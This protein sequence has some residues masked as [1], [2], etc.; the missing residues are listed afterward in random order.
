MDSVIQVG[1]L[2]DDYL[3]SISEKICPGSLENLPP[4]LTLLNGEGEVLRLMFD[5]TGEAE[6]LD[7]AVDAA[8]EVLMAISPSHPQRAIYLN[9]LGSRLRSRFDRCETLDAL[10]EATNLF[11]E[12]VNSSQDHSYKFM[13]LNNLSLCLSDWFDIT[14]EVCYLERAIRSARDALETVSTDCAHRAPCLDL[15]S[16]H[17]FSRFETT[18]TLEDLEE[19]IQLSRSALDTLTDGRSD[20]GMYLNNLAEKLLRRSERLQSRE[21][22]EEAVRIGREAVKAAPLDRDAY[23]QYLKNLSNSLEAL[24]TE[25]QSLLYLNEAIELGQDAVD[26][27]ADDDPTRALCL[28]SLGSHFL[29]R[30]AATWQPEDLDESIQLLET[31]FAMVSITHPQRVG[32]MSNLGDALASRFEL[33]GATEDLERAIQLARD[34]VNATARGHPDWLI[35]SMSLSQSLDIRYGVTLAIK[36][37]EEGISRD[38]EW[39]AQFE[40][41]TDLDAAVLAAQD[42]VDITSAG[43]SE[44]WRSL[45]KLANALAIRARRTNSVHDRERAILSKQEA[46]DLVC[47]GGGHY[48]QLGELDDIGSLL[49]DWPTMA[50]N[51]KELEKSIRIG[52]EVLES[53]PHAHTARS[54]FLDSLSARLHK[55]FQRFGNRVDLEDATELARA[56]VDATPAESHKKVERLNRLSCRLEDLFTLTAETN[57]LDESISLAQKVVGLTPSDHPFRAGYMN[58]LATCYWQRFQR[59]HVTA[60]IQEA[61]KYSTCALN[62]TSQ[63]HPDRAALLQNLSSN[64]GE[65]FLKTGAEEDLQDAIQL[66]QMAL[67]MI[68]PG[69]PNRPICLDYLGERL[70]DRFKRTQRIEDLEKSI[71]LG[72]EA[73]FSVP[74]DYPDRAMYLTNLGVRLRCSLGE[75]KSAVADLEDPSNLFTEALALPTA[76]PLDRIKAGQAAFHHLVSKGDWKSTRSVAKFV[77]ELLPNLMLRWITRDDQQHLLRHLARFSSLACAAVLQEGGT[78]AVALEILERG[79]GIIA[80]FAIDSQSDLSELK[81]KAPDLYSR[82]VSVR[83]SI[84]ARLADNSRLSTHA[85]DEQTDEVMSPSGPTISNAIARRRDDIKSLELLESQIREIQGFERF[86]LPLTPEELITFGQDGPVVS[87]NVT[88]HRSDAFLI[89][90]TEIIGLSLPKLRYSD[91]KQNVRKLV[92]KQNISR[93][94]PSTKPERNKELLRILEW[95]WDVAVKV[96]LQRLDLL[97]EVDDHGPLPRVWWVTSGYMGL[98]P[99][100]AAGDRFQSTSDFVVSSYTPILKALKYSRERRQ[101]LSSLASLKTLIVVAPETLGEPDLKTERE[102]AS[103]TTGIGHSN[104]TVLERPAKLD[105]LEDM[106]NHHIVHF[107]C[108]GYSSSSDPSESALLVRPEGHGSV[109][110]LSVRDLVNLGHDKAQLAYLSACS[111][112]ENASEELMDEVIHIASAF[113]L[114]GFLGV[115]GTLW[116]A[117]DKAAVKM[118]E[119]F[120]RRFAEALKDGGEIGR[121]DAAARALHNAV[122]SLRASR[123]GVKTGDPISWAPFI[124]IGA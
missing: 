67:D 111:T 98:T 73:V 10:T 43:N 119:E 109:Q 81:A 104:V 25:T 9:Q 2:S 37:L 42:A 113:Q 11:E 39:L 61:I 117:N 123:R 1:D 27:M 96:V 35:Y 6:Y 57:Y 83:L 66:G 88:E 26:C 45:G 92:G 72:R 65:R 29:K 28:D 62:A 23:P 84:N 105:V 44:R 102:V 51:P 40:A 16:S 95:L 71:Q 82:Y 13:Y 116:E 64:Y 47:V 68:P 112:A 114:V 107:A 48:D 86:L 24:F 31:A 76:P 94:P 58:T 74:Q 53:I 38:Q 32:F 60:D 77:M 63:D 103:I 50:E 59:S 49:T 22:L 3:T 93:G 36:D 75:T 80:S 34:A 7:R 12:A 52:R 110:R 30:F 56:A 108:H 79:R 17:V 8:R 54:V 15:L 4:A 70:N 118:S 14:S 120:Y 21:D 101:Q 121:H 18:D 99:I 19:A 20:C 115:I 46:L 33:T 91:L 90:A 69:N 85:G 100:H 55:R 124:H 78:P 5:K 106:K 41:V 122:V 97:H 89:T 87:F